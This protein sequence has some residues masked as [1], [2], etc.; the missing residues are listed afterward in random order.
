[1]KLRQYT[2]H[3][4]RRYWAVDPDAE[5]ARVFAW[6][7]GVYEEQPVLRPGNRRACPLFTRV[8]VDVAELFA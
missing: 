7:E 2:R 5:D 6:R 4:V 3:G 8:E 1:V